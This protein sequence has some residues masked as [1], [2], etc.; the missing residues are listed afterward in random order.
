M[1][2][3][4]LDYYD[5]ESLLES[6]TGKPG[7]SSITSKNSA[8]RSPK[9]AGIIK[10]MSSAI[11]DDTQLKQTTME[12]ESKFHLLEQA[13]TDFTSVGIKNHSTARDVFDL[14]R[15]AEKFEA[16]KNEHTQK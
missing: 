4:D 2:D 11:K 15:V 14:H 12:T 7:V 8:P 9:S 16:A 3:T 10:P 1:S 13:R 5:D 6:N